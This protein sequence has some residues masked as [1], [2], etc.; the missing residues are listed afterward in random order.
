MLLIL[1]CLV[2]LPLSGQVAMNITL[3]GEYQYALGGICDILA[4]GDLVFLSGTQRALMCLDVSNPSLPV[5]LH[6][7]RIPSEWG[8]F[9]WTPDFGKLWKNGDNL[10]VYLGEGCL[11]VFSYTQSQGFVAQSSFQNTNGIF[12][13]GYMQ[14]SRFI[15]K[16]PS[17]SELKIWDFSNT[18]AP[19]LLGSYLSSIYI[20]F[21][22]VAGNYVYYSCLTHPYPYIP[23]IRVLDISNPSQP[24]L[25]SD[26]PGYIENLIYHNGYLYGLSGPALLGVYDV[27]NP[28]SI[29][30]V[31]GVD[32]P[33]YPEAV[34]TELRVSDGFLYIRHD[35]FTVD[36]EWVYYSQYVCYDLSNPALPVPGEPIG[37][38]LYGGAFDVDNNRLLVTDY[39]NN[40]RIL[41]SDNSNLISEIG[42]FS[43]ST[44]NEIQEVDGYL[45]LSNGHIVDLDDPTR[46]ISPIRYGKYLASDGNYLYTHDSITLAKWDL[47]EPELPQSVATYLIGSAE[48]PIDNPL[49]IVQDHIYYGAHIVNTSLEP[50]TS[51]SAPQLAGTSRF[52][53]NYPYAY[54]AHI[55]GVKI[56]ETSDPTNPQL[57]NT[58]PIQ[59]GVNDLAISGNLLYVAAKSSPGLRILSLSDPVNPLITGLMATL[60]PQ[61]RIDH[62]G[63][64]VV[65][66]GTGGLRVIGIGDPVNPVLRGHHYLPGLN[67]R[68]LELHGYKAVVSHGSHLG[69]YDIEEALALPN[70]EEPLLPS[71]EI[72]ISAFPNPFRKSSQ[73]SV[74]LPESSELGLKVYNLK[75][76]LIRE[77]YSGF[78]T[79]GE[80]QLSWDGC[81]NHGQRQP[82]GIYFICLQSARENKTIKILRMK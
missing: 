47:S 18:Q 9:Q 55:E 73:I 67:Y 80:H 29:S 20:T 10:F 37:G 77:L 54:G 3:E 42:S 17:S 72:S 59:G 26:N 35:E 74:R 6:Y 52:V 4:E 62:L 71:P 76:Q 40:L 15:C 82:S 64:N 66:T 43:G 34:N 8:S 38:F 16:G 75:G 36:E 24:V 25:I 31:G 23:G 65:T 63:Y 27:T 60:E 11:G 46:Q 57:V 68:D 19:Q 45:Y 7:A 12:P 28:L 44:I 39:F 53:C 13:Y 41:A 30:Y 22:T 14:G 49:S 48:H 21:F 58:F 33:C 61:T 69:I 51:V 1:L 81:D 50:S 78:K 70:P 32:Y 79:A 56:F 2:A 5:R